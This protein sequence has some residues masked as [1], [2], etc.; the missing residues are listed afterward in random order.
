MLYLIFQNNK[1]T[2]SLVYLSSSTANLQSSAFKATH[3]EP[4]FTKAKHLS[5]TDRKQIIFMILAHRSKA[6][7]FIAAPFRARR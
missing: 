7:P 3:E 4:A 5:I 1:R 2:Q 6:M